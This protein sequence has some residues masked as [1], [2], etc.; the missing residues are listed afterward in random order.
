MKKERRNFFKK[1][2]VLFAFIF[3]SGKQTNSNIIIKNGW[4]LN[5][6]DI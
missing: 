4:I 5:K 3:I 2:F 1:T 6:A